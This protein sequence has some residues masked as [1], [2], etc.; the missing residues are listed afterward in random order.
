M[1]CSP[2]SSSFV[3]LKLTPLVLFMTCAHHN[4]LDNL[5][6]LNANDNIVCENHAMTDFLSLANDNPFDRKLR[7]PR[8]SLHLHLFFSFMIRSS[9][10][11]VKSVFSLSFEE[12]SDSLM[13]TQSTTSHNT[14]SLLP[15]FSDQNAVPF[16]VKESNVSLITT[17]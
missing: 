2:P 6:Q 1:F 17:F 13:E 4:T 15:Y 8:N 3:S 10:F 11:L 7:C 14:S 16:L 9:A 5:E 12:N